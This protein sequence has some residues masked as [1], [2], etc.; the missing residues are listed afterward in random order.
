MKRTFVFFALV[1]LYAVAVLS[2][3]KQKKVFVVKQKFYYEDIRDYEKMF[4]QNSKWEILEMVYFEGVISGAG[5]ESFV[6]KTVE[7]RD[8]GVLFDGHFSKIKRQLASV[9][10]RSELEHE[11]CGTGE[12]AS[13]PLDFEM[14]RCLENGAYYW[15][16]RMK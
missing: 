14:L 10:N 13:R 5:D 6:G 3:E 7:F 9:W 15:A 11:T 1:V 4:L 8:G 2:C 12:L 16:K